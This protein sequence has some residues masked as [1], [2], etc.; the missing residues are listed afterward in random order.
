MILS[1]KRHAAAVAAAALVATCVVL[2]AP[3]ADAAT[4]VPVPGST[5]GTDVTIAGQKAR[6]PAISGITVCAGTATAPIVTVQT[7]GGACTF[8]CLSVLVGGGSI[9]AQGLTVSY[10]E[11]GVLR[12]IPVDPPPVA[13]PASTCVFSVGSPDAPHPDCFIAIGPELGD[14][15]GD[16]QPVVNDALETVWATYGDALELVDNADDA[17]CARI[18]GA[19]DQYG[20]YY[21]F[22]DNPVGW[23]FAVAGAWTQY[24]CDQIPD[25]YDQWGYSYDFCES[26]VTWTVVAV[27]NVCN[28]AC[29]TETINEAINNAI[30]SACWR[31]E[32]YGVSVY[33]LCG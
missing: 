20:S 9:D 17:V 25:M 18:P 21:N 14:P 22:C 26:P 30:Y 33:T 8:A 28:L 16:L 4:C 1:T 12:T 27:Q 24:G 10:R 31:L 15:I 2:A 3:P 13:G 5:I 19:Y 32:R 6:V 11:D 7:S 29:N 23:T